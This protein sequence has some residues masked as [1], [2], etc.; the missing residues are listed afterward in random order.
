MTRKE[1][2]DDA[3]GFGKVNYTGVLIHVKKNPE[4]Y[5]YS[6]AKNECEIFYK[7]DKTAIS[8]CKCGVEKASN[9]DES[10]QID[11]KNSERLRKKEGI[12]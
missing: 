1:Q 7:N 8:H 5:A 9:T 4:N 2:L 10:E 11:C 6:Q 12:D 3:H